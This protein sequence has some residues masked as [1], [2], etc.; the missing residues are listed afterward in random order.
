[1]SAVLAVIPA[2]YHHIAPVAIHMRQAD[3]DEVQASSGKTPFA[4]LE[5]SLERSTMAHTVLFDGVPA[6][7][8]GVGDLNLLAR[9][10]SPWFLGTDLVDANAATFARASVFWRDQLL[11]RYDV[12]ANLVDDRNAASIRWLRWL[13]FTLSEP[14]PVGRGGEMFRLFELR[15]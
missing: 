2:E 11:Q 4:A 7:I 3:R 12:L 1:M 13:G 9:K 10:G 14:I 5:F 6:G 15:R 8:F